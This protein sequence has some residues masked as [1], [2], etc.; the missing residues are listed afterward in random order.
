MPIPEWKC[1]ESRPKPSQLITTCERI[2]T[3]LEIVRVACGGPAHKAG[4]RLGDRV[5]SVEGFEM[6]GG[7]SDE[8]YAAF[9]KMAEQTDSM[10][11]RLWRYDAIMYEKYSWVDVRA[12]KEFKG[13][14]FSCGLGNRGA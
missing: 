11:I 12:D 8:R 13:T 5:K 4:V 7:L 10:N 1:T 2:V 14:D 9:L 3:I 6:N